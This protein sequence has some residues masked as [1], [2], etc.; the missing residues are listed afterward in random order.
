VFSNNF[1]R[2]KLDQA[3][4]AHFVIRDTT[5]KTIPFD[6]ERN[7]RIHQCYELHKK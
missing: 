5:A 6:F 7:S 3:A 1:R 2:F 4:L